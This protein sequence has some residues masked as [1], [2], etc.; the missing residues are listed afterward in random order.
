[1]GLK[2]NADGSFRDGAAASFSH[3]NVTAAKEVDWVKKGAVTDVKNQLFCGSC[4]AFSATGAIEGAN[5]LYGNDLVA[6][7]EQELVDCDTRKDMGCS[8]GLMSYA[9]KYVIKNG[10][11]DTEEDYAYYSIDEYCNKNREDRTVVSIDSYEDVPTNNEAKLAQAVTAQPV[12]VAI[13]ASQLQFYSSGIVS[14]CC[15]ELDHGV[16]AVGYGE[17]GGVPYWKVKNSWGATWGEEGYFRLRKDVAK[18]AGTCNIA[19]APSYPIKK[20]PNPTHVPEVCGFL[21]Q[22]E[23]PYGSKCECSLGVMDLVCL[24]W[25]CVQSDNTVMEALSVS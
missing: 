5:F 19:Q 15:E 13:C 10:G 7:S 3:E 2:P 9:F 11:I 25:S 24:G 4:W 12:S 20:S 6:V 21:G 17:E 8:G 1:L 14:D 16:L 18:P 22:S 23:C